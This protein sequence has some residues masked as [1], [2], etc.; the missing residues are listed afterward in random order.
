MTGMP[1]L[2]KV[3]DALYVGDRMDA[4]GQT[5]REHWWIT[6]EK[7]H[8]RLRDVQLV[9]IGEFEA[10]QTSDSG[11]ERTAVRSG[12]QRWITGSGRAEDHQKIVAVDPSKPRPASTIAAFQICLVRHPHGGK[13][14]DVMSADYLGSVDI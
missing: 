13:F 11:G 9:S 4:H 14:W 10:H 2:R 3:S 1:T 5:L 7:L 6:T 12:Y 8:F